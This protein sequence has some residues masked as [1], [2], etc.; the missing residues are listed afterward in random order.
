MEGRF[1]R[2]KYS[3]TY[4]RNKSNQ[5]SIYLCEFYKDDTEFVSTEDFINNA[6]IDG[7]LLSEIWEQ[8]SEIEIF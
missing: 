3:L 8:I 2:K 4:A 1:Q 6:K 7:V 5:N